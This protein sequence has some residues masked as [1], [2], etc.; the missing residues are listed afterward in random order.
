MICLG[1]TAVLYFLILAVLE[2]KLIQKFL[3]SR[4]EAYTFDYPSEERVKLEKT[5]ATEKISELR[6]SMQILLSYQL[7]KKYSSY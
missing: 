7:L 1:V 5:A 3:V 2:F 4:K 6:G